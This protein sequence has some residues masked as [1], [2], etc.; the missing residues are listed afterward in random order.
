MSAQGTRTRKGSV[1]KAFT[2]ARMSM[3]AKAHTS[4]DKISTAYPMPYTTAYTTPYTTT[5]MTPPYRGAATD[6]ATA[7][8]TAAGAA[9]RG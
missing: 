4:A 5:Y 6:A 8:A 2:N 9:V 3:T 7:A 1:K